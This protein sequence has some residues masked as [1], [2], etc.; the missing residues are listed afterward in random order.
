[1][2]CNRID[3]TARQLIESYWQT[4]KEAGGSP[5]RMHAA[6]HRTH[7]AATA[8]MR[9]VPLEWAVN[10]EG[11]LEARRDGKP[12]AAVLVECAARTSKPYEVHAGPAFRC[13]SRRVGL[14]EA[15]EA[16]LAARPA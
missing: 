12:V 2:S 16:V 6:W 14:V 11:D 3:E 8:L 15:A 5:E 9:E 10:G 13:P 1:M 4:E 7:D